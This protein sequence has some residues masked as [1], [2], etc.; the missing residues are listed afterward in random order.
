MA[1]E[2]VCTDPNIATREERFTP[3]HFAAFYSQQHSESGSKN[4]STKAQGLS[5]NAKILHYLVY[6]KQKK[7]EVRHHSLFAINHKVTFSG[8]SKGS[9]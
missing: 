4:E 3:L 5:A 6:L 8:Q 7:V 1:L 2:I 9:I